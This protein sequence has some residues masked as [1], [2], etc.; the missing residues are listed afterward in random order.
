[1]GKGRGVRGE[2]QGQGGQGDDIRNGP[3]VSHTRHM[4]P[5]AAGAGEANGATDH[6]EARDGESGASAA[7][8]ATGPAVR[9]R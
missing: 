4:Q 6:D 8:I 2:A 9:R 5:A 1:M 3:N 7:Q